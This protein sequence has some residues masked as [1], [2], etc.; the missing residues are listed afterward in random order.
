[1]P[2]VSTRSELTEAFADP[3]R[4]F[5]EVWA[6][7][8]DTSAMFALVNG[9]LGW[10]M[11]IRESGDPGFSSRN[12]HYDG[13]AQATIEYRLE[14]GQADE[15]PASWALPRAEIEKALD[16]F[17]VTGRPPPWV[18]WHNDSGDGEAIG[19]AG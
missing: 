17:V 14:N 9:D 3:D 1:M 18:T 8:A 10:L 12:P 13:P 11:Y 16:H 19:I 5:L 4:R 6:E 15:Y 7:R 2:L